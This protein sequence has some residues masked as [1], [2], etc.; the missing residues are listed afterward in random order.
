MYQLGIILK[1]KK[2][3]KQYKVLAESRIICILYIYKYIF[4]L[5]N[6]YSNY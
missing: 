4:S 1:Y 3:F 5:L 6:P 2:Y